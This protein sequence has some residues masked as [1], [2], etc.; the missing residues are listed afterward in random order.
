MYGN[1][2]SYL[3]LEKVP[4]LGENRWLWFYG[5]ENHLRS[6]L[7]GGKIQEIDAWRQGRKRQFQSRSI[8]WEI[9]RMAPEKVSGGGIQMEGERTFWEQGKGQ[10]ETLVPDTQNGGRSRYRERERRNFC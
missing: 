10:E 9:D 3:V 6:G 8:Q 4:F 2:T 7:H 1:H 5:E